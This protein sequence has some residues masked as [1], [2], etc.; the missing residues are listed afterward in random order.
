MPTSEVTDESTDQSNF[1]SSQ[2]RSGNRRYTDYL[3]GLVGRF[4]FGVIVSMILFFM[5]LPMGMI[6]M[7]SFS[8]SGT[9]NFPPN[10]WTF[11]YYVAILAPTIS[12]I[13]VADFSWSVVI[14]SFKIGFISA[15]VVTIL[16]TLS[17]YAINNSDFLGSD[18]FETVSLLPIVVPLIV[19]AIGLVIFYSTVNISLGFAATTIAHIV[20]TFPFGVIV[21]TA[22]IA[23]V[24]SSLEEAARD[25][26]S[27]KFQIFR[28]IT[29]P[30]I[31]PG[32]FSAWI[33]AF[34]LSINEFVLTFFVSGT[35]LETLP[36]W[37]WDQL[38]FGVSPLTYVVSSLTLFFAIILILVVHRL[39]GIRRVHG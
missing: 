5:W 39:I 38:R 12:E 31:T 24:D 37:I 16:G 32:L 34:T 30:I 3:D 29:L 2:I 20:Y 27:T 7:Y 33:L 23:R 36:I 4:G 13:S 28:R 18:F 10:S 1:N 25:L 9:I 14:T 15:T 19:T 6:V 8:G 11:D 35:F 26:G 21:I 17:G 22:S